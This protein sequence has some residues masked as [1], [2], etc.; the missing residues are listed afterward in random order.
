MAT[1][2]TS[3]TV[4]IADLRFRAKSGLCLPPSPVSDKEI[5]D[6]LEYA[7]NIDLLVG[8]WPDSVSGDWQST[9]A[10]TSSLFSDRD[11]AP[12]AVSIYLNRADTYFDLWVMSIWN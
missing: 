10:D 7:I 9:L 5:V 2:L 12:E 11:N 3:L 1:R 4:N 8:G 6:L